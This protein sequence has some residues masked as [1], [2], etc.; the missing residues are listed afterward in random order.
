M[1]TMQ[2]RNCRGSLTRPVDSLTA[3]SIVW[4]W[5]DVPPTPSSQS[6]TSGNAEGKTLSQH[7]AKNQ[8]MTQFEINPGNDLQ[9]SLNLSP[10]GDI[11]STKWRLFRHL[12]T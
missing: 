8:S 5:R 10:D 6:S 9:R 1:G 12:L 11:A 3:P 2:S 7:Q 4:R